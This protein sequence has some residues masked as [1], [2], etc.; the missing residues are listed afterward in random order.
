M[1]I[2]EI[3]SQLERPAR[4]FPRAAVEE[5]VERREEITPELLRI[6]EETIA[7]PSDF[8]GDSIAH[9]FAMFLLAQF[10][11]SRAYP[12][13]VRIALLPSDVLDELFADL[14]TE[15]LGRLLASV[16]GG[17]IGEIQSLIENENADEYV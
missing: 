15:S 3:L 6:L 17:D 12:L 1:E 5:A 11:E 13:F 16:C 4:K 10:R 14:V 7:R 8:S 2:A 9:I